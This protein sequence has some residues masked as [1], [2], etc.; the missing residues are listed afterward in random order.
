MLDLVFAIIE[1]ID[2]I[3]E[4][5]GVYLFGKKNKQRRKNNKTDI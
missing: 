1:V 5:I 2:K 3:Y 4:C